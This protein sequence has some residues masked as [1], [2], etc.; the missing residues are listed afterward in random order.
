VKFSFKKKKKK[1]T[2]TK[3]KT[4][5]CLVAYWFLE[6]HIIFPLPEHE[7]SYQ[8]LILICNFCNKLFLFDY[9]VWP[10]R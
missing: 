3:P 5:H 7:F 8:L 10:A 9:S 6:V 2:K 4:Y 1:K